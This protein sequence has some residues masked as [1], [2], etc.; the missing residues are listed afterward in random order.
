VYSLARHRFL[1]AGIGRTTVLHFKES[2]L[3]LFVNRFVKVLGVTALMVSSAFA[4]TTSRVGGLSPKITVTPKVRI[5]DKV[6][7][8]KLTVRTKS[9]MPSVDKLQSMGRVSQNTRFKGMHIVLKSSDE[10]EFALQTLLDQQQDKS[11]GNYHQW[12]TPDTF[13]EKFGVHPADMTK[14]TDWLRSQGFS[15][16]KIAKGMRVIEFSGT[17]GQVEKAFHTEM[18]QYMIDGKL[19]VAN[20][21]DI[22]IPS[23]LAPVFG[24]MTKL[25]NIPLTSDLIAYSAGM[26]DGKVVSATPMNA[27]TPAAPAFSF[28]NGAPFNELVGGSDLSV[29]YNTTP[30]LNA[31]YTGAGITIG[32]IG[33]TDV[34]LSDV[35]V[36]RSVFG[37][38][39]NDPN[40]VQV[41][42]D[43]NTIPDDG[44]SDLDLEVSG[45]M[46]P[47]ATIN[48]YTANTFF[49]YGVDSAAVYA[50][51]QN[52]ADVISES[53]GGCEASNGDNTYFFGTLWEQAAAQGQSVFVSSGD[54][55]SNLCDQVYASYGVNALGSTPWNVSVGGT[56]FNEGASFNVAT[57]ATTGNPPFWGPT[58]SNTPYLNA[59]QYVPEQP[60]NETA[61]FAYTAANFPLLCAGCNL[62]GFVSGSSGVSYYWQKPNWQAGY[63]VPVTDV[64]TLA[65]PIAGSVPAT[66]G[67]PYGDGSGF[68]VT[69]GGT[70]YT[71]PTVTVTDPGNT[72]NPLVPATGTATVV[73]GVITKITLVTA[74]TNMDANTTV[75]ITD[76]TGKGAAAYLTFAA[77]PFQN[78]GPH[79]YMPDV[80]LNAAVYHDGNVFCSEGSCQ[81]IGN[82]LAT[83]N[84]CYGY[85]LPVN[86]L[87]NV[88]IVG[89][90]SVASPEMAGAQALIDSYLAVIN[91]AACKTAGLTT[92]QCGRQG[93]P[94]YY[95]YRVANAQSTTACIAQSYIGTGICGFHDSQK[96]NT[97]IPSNGA[98]T[99][100]Q[101]FN[102]APGYDLAIGLGS[103]DVAG[104]AY[105]WNSIS[106]NATT[107]A[108]NFDDATNG[109]A[110]APITGSHADTYEFLATVYPA[111]Q[112]A[113]VAPT[114]DV[115]I[116]AQAPGLLNF[117]YYG[118]TNGLLPLAYGFSNG[119]NSASVAGCIG[120]GLN[121]NYVDQYGDCLTN[122][123]GYYLSYSGM[124]G[125]LPGQTYNVYAHYSGDTVYG[126]SYSP[127]V[128]VS[129]TPS[130]SSTD[131]VPYT[132]ATNGVLTPNPTGA[133]NYGQGVYLDTVVC[134]AI[135]IS[136]EAYGNN[137][138]ADGTPTGNMTF[139]LSLAGTALPSLVVKM[140][141]IDEA[142]LGAGPNVVANGD[143]WYGNYPSSSAPALLAPGVYTITAAYAGDATFGASSTTGTI[144][145]GP[146]T[147][148][149]TVT[150]AT[151]DAS[152]TG[153]A[154]FY[155][156]VSTTDT[157]VGPPANALGGAPPV[158]TV[159]ITD[160]TATKTLC[161]AAVTA[162]Q[163]GLASCIAPAGSF[164]TTG[165]HTITASFAP[166]TG[167]GGST[168]YNAA[169]A[170]RTATV[171][172]AA[173]TTST[174]T[175]TQPTATYNFGTA[176]NVVATVSPTTATGTVYFY[177]SIS[178]SPVYLGAATL[179]TTT[180][181]ATLATATTLPAGVHIISASYGG[182]ATVSASNTT[183][184]VTLTINKIAAQLNL[185]SQFT[186]DI[187]YNTQTING[188]TTTIG[189]AMQV[190][191]NSAAFL[192]S[193]TRAPAVTPTGTFSFYADYVSQTSPGTLLNPVGVL[194]LY[195]PGGYDTFM[196][197]A[198][199]TL[200]TPGPHTLTAVYNGDN[201]Y[202]YSA[203]DT[204]PV[205]VGLT[206]LPMT[207]SATNI[208]TGEPIKLTATVTP[209]T[210]T[211]SKITGTVTFYDAFTPTGGTSNPP[212][213]LAPYP[214]TTPV[215][216]AI[217][218]VNGTLTTAGT[219]TATL[220]TTLAGVGT[221]LIT[222]VYSG[223]SRFYT[224]SGAVVATITSVTPAF[225]LQI[226][227]T[228]P[229]TL[230][231]ARGSSGS[232]P[233]QATVTG[234]WA[235]TAP[236]VC[237]GLPANSYCTFTFPSSYV[238]P[239]YFT[240]SGADGTFGPVTVTITTFLP[241]TTTGVKGSAFLWFPALLLAG[242]LGLRRKQLTLRQR[243]LM[244]M[245]IL[246]CGSLATTACSSL[247]M[248]TNPG[249]Y[250][251][252]VQA[253]GV[254]STPA[255]PN[256]QPVLVTPLTLTIQ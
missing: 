118:A 74:G 60:W 69:A 50:V 130:T 13:G 80:S 146:A 238:P 210:G 239:A 207:T 187:G 144:T 56:E 176:G 205:K 223:D 45:A 8:T 236:L 25:N 149:I 61:K 151:A 102:T 190:Q 141:P 111:S 75:T 5:V 106:F 87:C 197:N 62:G 63:G 231:I 116:E 65:Q 147:P 209:V 21:T 38:P 184:T 186:G 193:A 172:V 252:Q 96:G 196:A 233:I 157:V 152:T 92:S 26:K 6:D 242:L 227:P 191:F 256:I 70:G 46:A 241:H 140:D 3:S 93:N 105:A 135:G 113:T 22:S 98:S 117:N 48:F 221:H 216:T 67:V 169:T 54:D 4:G 14:V 136:D 217:V 1:A 88:G 94:N 225:F 224:S 137:S 34:L 35:Q 76:P 86:T 171:T 170:T 199:T 72:A 104:L 108:L 247:S 253:N 59:L 24:G 51:E 82:N 114:G 248:Q 52:V 201:N 18:H 240:F 128:A 194:G 243:Q 251:V 29:L 159:T 125:S 101:G 85:N 44:E 222:A 192:N 254:G 49:E 160:T 73:G 185:N 28:G 246:L 218:P 165:A 68:V 103:P 203:S 64:S 139:G 214:T 167:V 11:H 177:D 180:H 71:A 9:H 175:L 15:V 30:L 219:A 250:T 211:V 195:Q 37:L 161:T 53:Y 189:L 155:S 200:L 78:P 229:T 228:S 110:T 66:V 2:P 156:T 81:L 31:G 183:A 173:G 79:R 41:D 150:S 19:R 249:T 124:P 154:T 178:G 84:Y 234:N 126:G 16:D 132:Y 119:N 97:E 57:T 32:I 122:Y 206:T 129:I 17:S 133:Y 121:S 212:V 10:Q 42:T 213:V 90:T 58:T 127:T 142:V 115:V 134:S 107:L 20:S 226:V 158:G 245:A 182:S 39:V 47:K 230:S 55:G 89:G 232:F 109:S 244:L 215:V 220:T 33:Q 143:T 202:L 174:V 27:Q 164:T 112:T 235:G 255:S 166:G 188:V 12:M 123:G 168:Y 145:I 204:L 138:C 95:Y 163:K 162:A 179:S 99:T 36:Y 91:A 131:L 208:G 77:S 83:S 43:P 7:N 198:T 23:A 100:Y 120:G 148:T 153:P 40:I 181:T 237:V